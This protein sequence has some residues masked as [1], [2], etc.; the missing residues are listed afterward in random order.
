VGSE[1]CIRDRLRLMGEGQIADVT[2]QTLTIDGPGSR[3]SGTGLAA[4]Q[5][6]V[7]INC[8]VLA[9]GNSPGTLS[10]DGDLELRGGVIEVEISGL[11]D[12]QYDV[13]EVAGNATL[14]GGVVKFI[15][16][17]FLPQQN[18][19]ITFLQTGAGLDISQTMRYEYQGA[20]DGFEFE[21][22]NDGSGGLIFSALNNALGDSL[23][24]NGFE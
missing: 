1:M 6:T 17:E 18:D 14:S 12:G 4:F 21:V 2:G 16:S 15:F 9:P 19:Q 24:G 20:I 13:L 5:N 23:F 8:A 3:I 10:L 7:A 22:T 11:G